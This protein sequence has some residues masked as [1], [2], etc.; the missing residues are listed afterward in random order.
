VVSVAA[1]VDSA[2]IEGASSSTWRRIW[3]ERRS[4]PTLMVAPWG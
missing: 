1:D 3:P 4:R 2:W